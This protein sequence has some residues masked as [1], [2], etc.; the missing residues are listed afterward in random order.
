MRAVQPSATLE[1]APTKLKATKRM[2]VS[3][4]IFSAIWAMF[5]STEF[6]LGHFRWTTFGDIAFSIGFAFVAVRRF[7]EV[8]EANR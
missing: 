4:S 2:A 5:A 1:K 6:A 8:R 7:R 3:L